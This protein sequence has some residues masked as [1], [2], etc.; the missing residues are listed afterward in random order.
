MNIDIAAV[1]AYLNDFAKAI[2]PLF[3]VFGVIAGL[4]LL[5]T[6]A[7]KLMEDGRSGS[8]EGPNFSAIFARILIGGVMLQFSLSIDWT[9]AGMLG[10]VG[11]G[12]RS[13]MA[14]VVN[15]TSPT[16]N[17]ILDASFLWLAVIGV[18]GMFRGFL[19]FNKAASG[20][21]Q[22]GGDDFW[23]GLWHIIGG[24]ILINIGMS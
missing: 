21:G 23:S 4:Y 10:G 18:A 22:Q 6:A 5:G 9:K 11:S 15:N 24:A 8:G 19:K 2:L 12:A 17:A 13:S 7:K 3:S 1:F 16:W 20:E 14:L